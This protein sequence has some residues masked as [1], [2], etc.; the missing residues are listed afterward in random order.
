MLGI[1]TTAISYWLSSSLWHG[2]SLE[3]PIESARRWINTIREEEP[4]LIVGLF[5]TG[6][7]G[8]INDGDMIENASRAIA[9]EVDGFDIIFFGHDHKSC[10]KWI[11]NREG[12]E[13]LC[14]NASSDSILFN[15][16]EVTFSSDK[17]DLSV[18]HKWFKRLMQER[19]LFTTERIARN[20]RN[21]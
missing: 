7:T 18:N 8:G 2:I 21:R 15:E 3:N 10:K 16:V 6:W 17:K 13:V 19:Q 20:T 1:T 4:D 12:R 11:R 5:H 14:L 9:E